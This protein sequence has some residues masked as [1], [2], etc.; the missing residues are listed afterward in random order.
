MAGKIFPRTR[1]ALRKFDFIF[2]LI[3]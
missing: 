2:W 3:L 1:D